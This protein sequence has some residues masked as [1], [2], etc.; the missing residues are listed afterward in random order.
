MENLLY[1]NVKFLKGMGPKRADLFA[2]ELGIFT[3]GD[4]LKYYP[5]KYI[6]RTKVY[7][8][9]EIS[10]THTHIQI[11]GRIV[12][13]R[14]EGPKYRQRLIAIFSDQTGSIELVWFQG[15][16]WVEKSYEIGV[17][18]IV[19]GKPTRFGKK[20]NVAH[21]EIEPAALFENSVGTSLYPQYSLTEKLRS[22]YISSKTFQKLI[23]GFFSSD[24][25]TIP[26]TLP[27]YLVKQLRLISLQ[28]ALHK[29]HLPSNPE[30][31]KKSEYRLK[32]EE[33]F[34]IQLKILKQKLGRSAHFQGFVFN[35]VG[36]H[37]NTFYKKNLKFK[38]TEAQ[39][40]VMREIRIDLRSGK[41]MNRLLQGDVG[42]GKTLIALMS[43]LLALDNGFQACLMA[44]TEILAVQHFN[45]IT[46]F[47]EGLSLQVMLLTGSTKKKERDS[48]YSDLENGS[49]EI[50][51]GTHAL[52]EDPVKFKN[53]GLVIIDEQHRFGVAQRAKLWKKNLQPPHVLVMTATPIPRTLAMTLY[54]DLDV[55]VID[56]LP[57]GRKPI[58]T[59]HYYESK[60]LAM[61]G[62]LRK[63]IDQGRQVYIVYP[64]ILES[65]KLDYIA[66]EDGYAGVTEY[67]SPPEYT[68]VCLHGKMKTEDKDYGMN[69]FKKGKAHIMVAT[70]VIEVG[71]DIPNATVMV[72]ESAERYG[73]SQLHQLRGRVGRG[74]EQSFCILMSGYKLSNEAKKRIDTLVNTNDGFEIAEVDLKLRGPGDIEGTQQSGI[75]F[76]LKIANLARDGQLLQYA[77]NIAEDILESDPELKEEKNILLNR[78]LHNMKTSAFDWSVIS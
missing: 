77:R 36:D 48:I 62:F 35:K 28:E 34:G 12:S 71:V 11:R 20:I 16:K 9:S 49:I 25:L 2:R 32:F 27:E 45:T 40:K 13:F 73:L 44:P 3:I 63:Q 23:S 17:E 70:T 53:L 59:F 76:D 60:R 31:I 58:Q 69:L 30:E 65:E 56:E 52:L 57:P 21:P 26:E 1:T 78:M 37:F 6:D 22:A 7:T 19:F 61:Y 64:L 29:I 38:L 50:L 33:L 66:L 46:N 47:L 72:I 41:Q 4:L 54:G 55:S 43:A 24:K 18:Y 67:F 14:K 5:Y 39:K 15:A 68:V 42:S 10:S 75:P 8:I 74:A 51:I